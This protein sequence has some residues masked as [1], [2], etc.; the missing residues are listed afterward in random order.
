MKCVGIKRKSCH[1]SLC[2][3]VGYRNRRWTLRNLLFYWLRNDYISEV[4]IWAALFSLFLLAP[5]PPVKNEVILVF[6]HLATWLG[7]F[8]CWDI[9]MRSGALEV[10][11]LFWQWVFS[12]EVWRLVQMRWCIYIKAPVSSALCGCRSGL[13]PSIFSF[14]T[15]LL[16]YF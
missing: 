15:W 3:A 13:S 8:S 10:W 7:F 11:M 1:G 5:L 14:K 9:A 6:H 2:S 4:I 16:F 12:C